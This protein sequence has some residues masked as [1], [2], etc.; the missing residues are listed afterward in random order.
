MPDLIG[1]VLWPLKWAVELVLVGWHALFTAVGM[2][3]AAGLTWVL[4]IIGLVLVVRAALIP[5]SCARSRA[6]AR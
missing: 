3:P 4:S 2:A 5:S 1:I 6:S